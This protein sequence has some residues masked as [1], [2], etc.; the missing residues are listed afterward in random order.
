M[1]QKRSN[2]L[3]FALLEANSDAAADFDRMGG[4]NDSNKKF[5]RLIAIET[6]CTDDVVLALLSAHPEVVCD[7]NTNHNFPIQPF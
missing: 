3:I 4:R 2:E 7:R 1:K 5:P 6:K